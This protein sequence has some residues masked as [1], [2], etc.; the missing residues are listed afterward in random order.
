MVL[1]LTIVCLPDWP[2]ANAQTAKKVPRKSTAARSRSAPAAKDWPQFR[3]P[4]GLGISEAKGLP[5]SWSTEQNVRWKSELPG[6]GSSSPIVLGE[7]VFVT[8]YSGYGVRGAAG[9]DMRALKRHVLCF[10][11]ATGKL[12]WQADV[13]AVLPESDSVREHG[14]AASTPACDGERLYVFFGKSG[15]L[16]FDLDG[17]QLWKADVGTQFHGWGSAASPVLYQDLVI[18]NACVESESLIALDRK[19]GRER[20]RAGGIKESWNTPL[21]VTNQRGKPELVVAVLGKLLGF[22]PLTGTPLWSCNNDITWYIAPSPVAHAGIVYS[23]GGRSGVAAVAVRTGGTGD[24]T[25]THRLWTGMKGSN[26]SSPV[27]HE[28]HLYWMR[29]NA[30]IAYCAEALTGKIVYEERLGGDSQT[31]ASPVL[32]DGKLYYVSRSGRTF[33]LKAEPQ[34]EQLAVNDLS[35]G[36]TFDASPAVAGNRIYLRSHRFLYCVGL[37]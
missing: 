15:V 13:P 7:R 3:G 35:D 30:G 25:Q 26:V 8:C 28:G 31:Y 1:L 22:D 19:T 24:V 36:S 18:I 9:G 33:V 17:R 5:V 16:A 6:A 11:S 20:W 4:G 37:E 10:N 29:D 2:Q 14:Y 27:Y 21:I 32:A 12:V 34:F 23:L